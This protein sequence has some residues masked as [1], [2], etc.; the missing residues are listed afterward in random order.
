MRFNCAVYVYILCRST[1]SSLPNLKGPI[2][3]GLLTV[4]NNMPC[5]FPRHSL[6]T[7]QAAS[8][9][10]KWPSEL[11]GHLTAKNMASRCCSTG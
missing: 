5:G 10:V 9:A 1:K 4:G 2:T 11:A 7:R 3:N 8:Q 6:L